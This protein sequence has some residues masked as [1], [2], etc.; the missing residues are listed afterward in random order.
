MWRCLRRRTTAAPINVHCDGDRASPWSQRLIDAQDDCE[1]CGWDNI[2]V[3]D[4]C[5]DRKDGQN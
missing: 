3:T 1:L 4:A 5:T 2:R